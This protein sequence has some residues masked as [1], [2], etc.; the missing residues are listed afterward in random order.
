M[1]ET[2][3]SRAGFLDIALTL[4]ASKH[5]NGFYSISK[6]WNESEAEK[7]GIWNQWDFIRATYKLKS[8][9]KSLNKQNANKILQE[10]EHGFI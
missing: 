9:I 10:H 7:W 3:N 5:D 2:T 4:Y 1:R 8:I 6:T